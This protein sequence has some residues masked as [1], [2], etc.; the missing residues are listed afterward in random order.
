MHQHTMLKLSDLEGD[1]QDD[2]NLVH[3]GRLRS[4]QEVCKDC[5]TYDAPLLP[6]DAK[7]SIRNYGRN[8]RT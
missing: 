5:E 4:V 7:Y 6:T 1:A 3:L 8:A 2:Q